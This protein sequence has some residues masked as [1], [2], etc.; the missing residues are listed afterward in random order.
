MHNL[1]HGKSSG[2]HR[3]D[4]GENLMCDTYS[5]FS[6]FFFVFVNIFEGVNV[7]LFIG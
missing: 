4:H 1:V 5:S 6:F 3:L 2:G 7:L